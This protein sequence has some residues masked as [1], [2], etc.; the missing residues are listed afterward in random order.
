MVREA[1]G[2]STLS[3]TMK[4]AATC[5]LAPYRAEISRSVLAGKPDLKLLR[6]GIIA[7]NEVQ[8]NLLSI[9]YKLKPCTIWRNPHLEK[10]LE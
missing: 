1:N 6:S 3:F 5:V 9:N 2:L 7:E 4:S 8:T 10:K